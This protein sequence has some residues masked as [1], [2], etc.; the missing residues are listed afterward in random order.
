LNYDGAFYPTNVPAGQNYKLVFLNGCESTTAPT[1][2]Q[3]K[4]AFSAKALVGWSGDVD[5]ETAVP[6]SQMFWPSLAGHRS[7][8]LAVTRVKEKCF[9]AGTP[10]W[11]KVNMMLTILGDGTTKL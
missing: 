1:G 11:I 10:P 9:P 3:F 7:V 8:Q 5:L 2:N 4:N 6:V